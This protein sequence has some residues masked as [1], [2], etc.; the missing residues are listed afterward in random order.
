MY[1]SSLVWALDAGLGEQTAEP[2]EWA[3]QRFD[4]GQIYYQN[5]QYREALDAYQDALAVFISSKKQAEAAQVLYEIGKTQHV[6]EDYTEAIKAFQGARAIFNSEGNLQEVGNA[7]NRIG[8]AYERLNYFQESLEAFYQALDIFEE[9]GDR[10]SQ[11]YALN[12]IGL[13]HRKLGN[14]TQALAF[15]RQAANTL[16]EDVFSR[17]Y[18]LN[19][20][21]TLYVHLGQYEQALTAYREALTLFQQEGYRAEEGMVL[22]SLGFAYRNQGQYENA[23]HHYRQSLEVRYALERQS[24][25]AETLNN[26]GYVYSLL[27]DRNRA[28]A[29]LQQALS[30][31]QKIGNAERV[32]QTLETLATVYRD[33]GNTQQALKA[34]FQAIPLLRQFGDRRSEIIAYGNLGE[35]FAWEGQV[36]LAV[37][38]YKK[39]VNLSEAIRK[40]LRSLPQDYQQTYTETVADT[41]RQLADLLLQQNRVLEAQR[42]LDLLK[43]QELDDYLRGVRS[44]ISTQSGIEYG[45]PEQRILDL[46]KELLLAAAEL[47]ILRDRSY[48][49]LSPREQA[50]LEELS[51]KEGELLQNFDQFIQH[52]EVAEALNQLS[53]STNRQSLEPAQFRTLQNNL[54]KLDNAVLVYPLILED[55]LELVLVSPNSPPIRRPV[56]VT[57]AELNRAIVTFRQGLNS[58]SS[59]AIT[60]ARQLYEWLI[61]PLEDDLATLGVETIVY[62]P[63]GAL[64][65]VPLAA[66]HDGSDWL[67]T[68]F[69]V[70]HI[71]AAS[72]TDFSTPSQLENPRM[73][74]AAC[75]VCSFSFDIGDRRFDFGDLPFT[76]VE[77]QSLADTI[78]NTDTLM[79]ETFSPTAVHSRIGSYPLV[80]LATHAALV[81]G[82]LEE[83]FIVFGNG[84]RVNL[85]GVKASNLTNAE[86]VVLSACETRLAGT[87]LGN[88]S[89]ILGF[90]YLMQEA[91]AKAAIA[92]LWAVS[93]GGTQELMTN[94]Y[95]AL[96]V[97]GMTKA[98]ALQQAQIALIT[99]NQIDA[100]SGERFTWV[101]RNP[102]AEELPNSRLSHPYFWAPF[103]LIGNGL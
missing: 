40:E 75:V 71:T 70:M 1:A 39:S 98:E 32:G 20:L 93:D 33:Q 26:L 41:Y 24:G 96:L 55:R 3:A 62:A 27:G 4:E 89:E 94:F 56:E 60:P 17:I 90:G 82:Q 65:Y 52:P 68:Q 31:H 6:L 92:S 8:Q 38:F 2:E 23:L 74:A 67:A 69:K 22:H 45:P 10:L 28:I 88:G 63:D 77:V 79:N 36:E 49:D 83:S 14:Y 16:T 76:G 78:P 37:L 95:N 57:A 15:H 12:N 61:Q 30:T 64:R 46:Y 47:E 13:I 18:V 11:G 72:L 34:Y 100:G 73:L 54:A 5:E 59:D 51:H 58:P 87:D 29:V 102:E 66:L 84:E 35:L 9:T 86:H 91:G 43:V 85:D 80:H 103:I 19:S 50:R 44:T 7:I 81:P 99:G 48:D 53:Q 25:I 97:E 101:P 21:G 42:V